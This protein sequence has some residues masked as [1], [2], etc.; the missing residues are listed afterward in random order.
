MLEKRAK[1]PA[2]VTVDREGLRG[3]KRGT[4]VMGKLRYIYFGVVLWR[5]IYTILQ[6]GKNESYIAAGMKLS[7]NVGWD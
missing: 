4:C 1:C 5:G 6:A 7:Y 3:E 2:R